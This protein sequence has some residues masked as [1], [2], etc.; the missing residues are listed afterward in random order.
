MGHPELT[1]EGLITLARTTLTDEQ[2][3]EE[4]RRLMASPNVKLAR[5]EEAI[6]SY[7]RQQLYQLRILEKKGMEL[8]AKGVTLEILDDS[9]FEE[10][11]R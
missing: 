9:Y 3:D 8:A 4:I 1:K 11:F 10:A 2:V 7:K 6:R 5:R